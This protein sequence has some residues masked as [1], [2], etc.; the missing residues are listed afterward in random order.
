VDSL[1][2]LGL[3][4]DEQWALNVRRDESLDFEQLADKVVDGIQQGI[5][6]WVCAADHQ[7]YDL[8]ER[9]RKRGIKAPEDC[10]I[11][12]FDGIAPPAGLPRLTT[13][14]VPFIEMGVSSVI[15][16]VERMQNPAAQRRHNLVEGDLVLGDS[17]SER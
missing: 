15:R 6:A 17:T 13:I 12:G 1:F 16:L 10:S 14:K 4:F 7:A 11:T 2:R 5:T 9:L 8:L 3:R